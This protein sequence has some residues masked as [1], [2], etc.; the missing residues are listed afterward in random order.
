MKI[1]YQ[2]YKMFTLRFYVQDSLTKKIIEV[3]QLQL[4]VYES[5]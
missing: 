2:K 3:T 4:E 1:K 5:V